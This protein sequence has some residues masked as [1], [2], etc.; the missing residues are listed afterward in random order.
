[1]GTELG[2]ARQTNAVSPE[3]EPVKYRRSQYGGRNTLKREQRTR[4]TLLR[5]RGANR[6]QRTG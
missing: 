4:N 5:S 2:E 6:E 3:P 1:M